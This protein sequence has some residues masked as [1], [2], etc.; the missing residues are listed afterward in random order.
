[1]RALLMTLLPLFLLGVSLTVQA[2][3]VL[4]GLW[5]PVTVIRDSSGIPHIF[6]ENDHDVFFMQGWV[7]AEDRLFQMDLT[8][9]QVAGT[10][11]ELVGPSAVDF[12]DIFFRNLG[13][14]RAAKLSLN[15]H[16]QAF[17]DLLQAYSD[18]VNAF[19]ERAEAANALPPEYDL[20]QLTQ[21][22]RWR[23]LDSVLVGKGFALL[24]SLN[25]PGDI[26]RTVTL[27]TFR[28]VGAAAGFDGT[29]LFFEDLLRSAPFDRA[30]TVP[31]A[32]GTSSKL[33]LTTWTA[34]AP[35]RQSRRISETGAR[36]APA[37]LEQA[38]AYLEEL[39][40]LPRIPGL[41][42]PDAQTGGGSNTWVVSGAHTRNGRSLLAAD[43][44]L[45]LDSPTTFHQIHL[46]APSLDVTGSGIP[47]SPCVV[48]GHN[49]DLAWGI[50]N[51]R[52]D[53][54]DTYAELIVF[55]PASPSGLSTVH[56]GGNEPLIQVFET[57]RANIGG[58]VVP[59]AQR[60]VLIVPRRNNGS[61]ITPPQFDSARGVFTAFSLQS[62]GFSATRDPEGIC[63][64]NR[65]SNLEEFKAA[66]QLV[67]FASQNI[68]Y[69][70]TKGNIAFFV[71]G[72][73]P[74]REDLQA[75]LPGDP[76]A[77]P[78]LVRDGTGG[79][80]WISEPSLPPN[81]AVAFKIL[82][83]EEMPQTVNP[84]SGLIVN[85]N[86]DPIGNALDND[87]LNDPRPGGGLFYLSWGGSQFS[88]RAGRITRQLREALE[89]DEHLNRADMIDL[90]A[91]V[92]LHDAEVFKPAI[93]QAFERALSGGAHPDLAALAAD[94]RLQ[95][96]MDRLEAWDNSTPTGLRE[97]FDA[98]R[99]DDDDDDEGDGGAVLEEEEIENSVAASIYAVWRR[100]MAANTI[101]ATLTSVG[102]SPLF[103]AREERVTALRHLLDSFE[104]NQ[105]VGASGLDFF[106]G[107][108]DADAPT[109]RD[110]LVLRSLA[111]A[112][113]LLA[114]DAFKEAFDNSSNQSDYRWGRLHRIVFDHPLGGVI[115]DFNVPPG[116][117]YFPPPLGD[118]PGI[119][120]DGGFETVDPG[121]PA[122]NID[123]LNSNAF[124]FNAGPV[125]R[126]V[127]KM[128]RR[129]V[130]AVT[131][132]PGGQSAVPGSPF[133]L[134]LLEAWLLN[135]SHPLL[136]KPDEIQADAVA[137]QIFVPP[138]P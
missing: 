88:I 77:P 137:T 5:A 121:N 32:E 75:A 98:R 91:D 46:V 129:R 56:Q 100:Q 86:N 35:S 120:T 23:P 27:E 15:A 24:T 28:A 118:L 136:V 26:N 82:P 131:A 128:K 64:F 54:S 130:K 51:T 42:D 36:L 107:P 58:T 1:M 39:R 92:V 104:H 116:F 11:A 37:A 43:A 81:Q 30:A 126:F 63:G 114:S 109:R 97:G 102:L 94:P 44:H 87:P 135:E 34:V 122:A 74:L 68:S 31:D 6:A 18:G 132:L 110:I 17:R 113:D 19:I 90:Q 8:R 40:S 96:A 99:G 21:V 89:E 55:D 41:L 112:L 133:Y 22:S 60:D 61:L 25:V 33:D 115:G 85:A 127:G 29:K 69:A 106:P 71:S 108:S 45:G 12:P 70:D 95:E 2:E 78:F 103:N 123:V 67:D 20:L 80:E 65:A 93:L 59:F 16:P 47:G 138:S 3:T 111:E 13:L 84:A 52:L 72:E 62:T 66:L 125:D 7:H 38:R 83:F 48:R 57:F 53:I 49:R 124:T 73:V 105:G 50:T 14:Q 101:D 117:G 79:Q 4:P 134:S 76:V 9:R 119:P 10:V